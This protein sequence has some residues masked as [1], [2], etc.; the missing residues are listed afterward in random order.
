MPTKA[1]PD[2]VSVVI[3]IVLCVL[4]QL[5][6]NNTFPYHVSKIKTYNYITHH[7]I[8]SSPSMVN[9]NYVASRQGKCTLTGR[10]LWQRLSP[11]QGCMKVTFSHFPFGQE[12]IKKG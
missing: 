2:E 12:D 6:P 3:D 11:P 4:P 1:F 8:K 9:C 7:Y 10:P 5:L